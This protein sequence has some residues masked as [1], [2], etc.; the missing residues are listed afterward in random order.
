[1]KNLSAINENK[2]NVTKEYVDALA[3]TEVYIGDE[4]DAP[5]TTKLL[6]DDEF[7]DASNA[8]TQIKTMLVTVPIGTILPYSSNN[9]PTGFMIC[10]GRAIDRTV[11]SILFNLIGTTYG[12][13]DGSNT[14]NIPN[15]KGKV[16][17]G[18]D[19]SDS[20]FDTIGETGGYKKHWHLL[21]DNGYSK[22][23]IKNGGEI[24]YREK[25]V[26]TWTSNYKAVSNSG[27]SASADQNYGAVLGGKTA[28]GDSLQPYITLNYIIKVEEA[29]PLN[30]NVAQLTNTYS[31]STQD[32]YTC[33][34]INNKMESGRVTCD[35]MYNITIAN[36]T[37]RAY[38]LTFKN[39][40]SKIP[41]VIVTTW[42]QQYTSYGL[43]DTGVADITTTG[44]KL[45]FGYNLTSANEGIEYLVIS[46]DVAEET[47]GGVS[48]FQGGS[49][50]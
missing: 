38:D 43:I 3:G 30:E 40:Y 31:S 48:T 49:S 32:G 37:R 9:I 2:D 46:N 14:F 8:N 18:L 15:L 11:Y 33:N 23:I 13:G 39:T 42:N 7:I 1:M 34:Y 35:Q 24:H 44:C 19:S 5:A 28:D 25:S 21:D 27:V 47:S 45:L 6:I 10:D 50:E 41:T 4:Q 36:E 20:D 26:A 17:V 29:T 22:I 12:A 16:P